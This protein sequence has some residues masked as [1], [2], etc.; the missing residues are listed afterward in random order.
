V[1]EVPTAKFQRR[2]SLLETLTRRYLCCAIPS[3]AIT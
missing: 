3:P 2:S 1:I